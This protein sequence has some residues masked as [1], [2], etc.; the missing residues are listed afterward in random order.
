MSAQSSS[1]VPQ[2]SHIFSLYINNAGEALFGFNF[3]VLAD[4]IKL[5]RVINCLHS[6]LDSFES[7]CKCN[8]LII[9][10]VKY[11]V[12]RF[13]KNSQVV[14]FIAIFIVEFLYKLI[15]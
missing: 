1:D 5:F 7:W 13:S 15:K 2:G 3:L 12:F 4:D 11:K 8:D 10:E 14:I 6:D 9:N